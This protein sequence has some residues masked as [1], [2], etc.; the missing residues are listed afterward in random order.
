MQLEKETD[1]QRG[2]HRETLRERQ[3]SC[4]GCVAEIKCLLHIILQLGINDISHRYTN[5]NVVGYSTQPVTTW[6]EGN[7]FQSLCVIVSKTRCTADPQT[8][9][10]VHVVALLYPGVLG[11]AMVS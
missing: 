7:T 9:I 4:Q 3:S 8:H 2:T 6:P 1:K 11:R 10:H 5:F